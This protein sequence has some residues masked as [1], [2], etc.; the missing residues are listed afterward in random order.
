M[1]EYES[2]LGAMVRR[3]R[4]EGVEE[5]MPE[6]DREDSKGREPK[7]SMS[8]RAGSPK[9]QRQMARYQELIRSPDS[10]AARQELPGLRQ[11]LGLN[12]EGKDGNA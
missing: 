10:L 12:S 1:R 8:H 5:Q 9:W 2:R 4:H 7:P 6:L 11:Q 3:L